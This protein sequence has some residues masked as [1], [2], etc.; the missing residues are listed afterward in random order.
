MTASD[1]SVGSSRESPFRPLPSG[2]ILTSIIQAMHQE[3][4]VVFR[5]MTENDRDFLGHCKTIFQGWTWATIIAQQKAEE[6]DPGADAFLSRGRDLDAR[7]GDPLP[8]LWFLSFIEAAERFR[9]VLDY[10]NRSGLTSQKGAEPDSPGH[11]LTRK[12]GAIS[13]Q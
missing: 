11:Y 13:E 5:G 1:P 6:G 4:S 8:R 3:I 12:E 9:L 10:L 2:A 7:F